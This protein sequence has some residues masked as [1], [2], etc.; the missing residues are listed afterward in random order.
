MSNPNPDSKGSGTQKLW[1]L[2]HIPAKF[3]SRWLLQIWPSKVFYG[4]KI[5]ALVSTFPKLWVGGPHNPSKNPTTDQKRELRPVRWAR[6]YFYMNIHVS[7]TILTISVLI[8]KFLLP[9]FRYRI[10]FMMLQ[11]SCAVKSSRYGCSSSKQRWMK[12]I[13]SPFLLGYPYYVSKMLCRTQL[14]CTLLWNR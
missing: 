8:F 14:W 3:P 13:L 2:W 10:M 6:Y 4:P 9:F 1:F 12:Y 11:R 5:C 7:V